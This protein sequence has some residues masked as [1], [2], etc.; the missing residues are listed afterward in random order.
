MN[1]LLRKEKDHE[2]EITPDE[3]SRMRELVRILYK[4]FGLE[5]DEEIELAHLHEKQNRGIG[6]LTPNQANILRGLDDHLNAGQ[7]F[8]DKMQ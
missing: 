1:D 8:N 5:P 7:P 3:S 6:S 2:R 4:T